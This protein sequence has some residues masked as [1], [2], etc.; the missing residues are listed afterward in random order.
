IWNQIFFA[1]TAYCLALYVQITEETKK[2]A[3]QTL[4]LL[5]I[6]AERSWEAFWKAI[7]RKPKRKSKGRQ[8]SH[9]PRSPVKQN[10]AGVAVVKPIGEKNVLKQR[11][12]LNKFTIFWITRANLLTLLSFLFSEIKSSW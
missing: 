4:E 5:R 12:T 9:L 10:D 3:W 11:N 7:H 2:S 8:K 6:Y 1:M